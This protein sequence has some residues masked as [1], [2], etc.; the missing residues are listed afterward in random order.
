VIWNLIPE[1]GTSTVRG[2]LGR[3]LFS[4]ADV[5]KRVGSLSGGEAARLVFCRIMVQRPNVLVLDEPT[6][7]LDLE[8][9]QALVEALG[10]FEG[11]VLFVS[12]DRAFV[13]ALATRILEVTE[14]GFRDFPGTYDEYLARCGDDHLDAETVVLRAKR[15]KLAGQKAPDAALAGAPPALSWE[16]QKRRNN[17]KKQ[18]PARRDEVVAAIE[19]AEARKAVI[20]AQWCEPGFYEATDPGQIAE[21]ER[22]ERELGPRI[23]A[24]LAEWEA[25]EAE[26]ESLAGR[27]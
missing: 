9:I 7:H 4:G 1:E 18:L 10:A 23:E 22:E 16:E 2:Q 24:L 21:L 8:S 26:I 11:T 15:D 25:L 19:A 5:E 17:R 27:D 13:S 20:Q 14:Q 12:H 6:N 3:V